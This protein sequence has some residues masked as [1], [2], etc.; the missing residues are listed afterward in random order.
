[1]SAYFGQGVIKRISLQFSYF[2]QGGKKRILSDTSMLKYVSS[3]LGRFTH[4]TPCNSLR[5]GRSTA[6]RLITFLSALVL[7]RQSAFLRLLVLQLFLKAP[8]FQICL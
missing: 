5:P 6:D 3:R 7:L 8:S 2:G 4:M 1:M